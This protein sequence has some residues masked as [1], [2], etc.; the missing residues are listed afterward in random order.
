MSEAATAAAAAAKTV[1]NE[2]GTGENAPTVAETLS[3]FKTQYETKI[4]ELNA[5]LE[6]QEKQH[7][8]EIADILTGAEKRAAEQKQKS[9]EL[10]DSVNRVRAS[11]G[12]T[13]ID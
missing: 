10:K 3:A 8:K 6:A 9:D 5:K 11:L 13:K 2:A 7:A 1:A 4:A 12:L